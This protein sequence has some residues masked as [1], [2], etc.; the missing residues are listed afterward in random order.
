MSVI[1][2]LASRIDYHVDMVAVTDDGMRRYLVRLHEVYQDT[3]ESRIPVEDR[4]QLVRYPFL[5]KQVIA[6]ISTMHGA[7]YEYADH[8]AGAIRI[9]K[10]SRRIE[11]LFW[12]P[13]PRY[14]IGK[15]PL[16][17]GAGP[18]HWLFQN[19]E[20]KDI[21]PFEI[22]GRCHVIL[23]DSVAHSGTWTRPA[24]YAELDLDRS[25][26][27]WSET[28]ATIR[29]KDELLLALSDI[30]EAE[31]RSVPLS[32]FLT[33]LKQ[34]YV[35]LLGDFSADGR[36]RLDAIGSRLLASG[37][38]PVMLDELPELPEYD[39]LQKANAMAS[40]CRLVVVDDSSYAGHLAEIPIALA[41][42]GP[43]IVARI[44]GGLSSFVGKGI[45]AG[46]GG[47]VQ[48]IS[49]RS[50]TLDTVISAAVENAERWISETGKELNSAYPWRRPER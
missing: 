47:R 21:V 14:R 18:G 36:V 49:Y 9:H 39:L 32:R 40:V 10:S 46:T 3:V 44:E 48:E 27:Y 50:D 42:R 19:V 38:V 41:T 24:I 23:I 13:P 8:P 34:R 26:E 5:D 31:R 1:A 15:G 45:S 6:Y 33:T 30:R 4:R 7:G 16:A 37:Y 35:L 22:R 17:V 12:R 11:D 20:F 2:T 25:E 29:A 28:N 43:L